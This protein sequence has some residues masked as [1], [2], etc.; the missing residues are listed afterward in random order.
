[1]CLMANSLLTLAP[2]SLNFIPM[3]AMSGTVTIAITSAWNVVAA[4][5]SDYFVRF[6]YHNETD[7]DQFIILTHPN[8][9]TDC[10][11]TELLQ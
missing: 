3:A 7:G 4:V 9:T 2:L 5:Y 1:M 6:Y 11:L 8:C 10:P